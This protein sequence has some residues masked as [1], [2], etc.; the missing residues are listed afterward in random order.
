MGRIRQLVFGKSAAEFASFSA[1]EPQGRSIIVNGAGDNFDKGRYDISYQQD[2]G[3]YFTAGER[4]WLFV[5]V[6]LDAIRARIGYA[7]VILRAALTWTRN[8]YSMGAATI[9][10]YRVLN[11]GGVRVRY[12]LSSADANAATG[13]YRDKGALVTWD[14]DHYGPI[15]GTD[16]RATAAA[17]LTVAA[18]SVQY[19]EQT[20]TLTDEVAYAM[21]S[22]GELEVM[23]RAESELASSH[24][25]YWN[26]EGYRPYLTIDYLLPVE[27]YASDASGNADLSR[28]YDNNTGDDEDSIDLGMLDRP[29]VGSAVR[30]ILKNWRSSEIKHI[31]IWDDYPTWTLPVAA[32]GNSGTG[33]LAHVSPAEAAVSQKYT[34]RFFSAGDFEVK[35]ESY[36]DNPTSLHPAF[37]SDASW[38]GSTATQFTAPSGGLVIPTAAWSGTP[39]VGD[40]FELFVAGNSTL[41]TWL[42]DSNDMVEM[43]GDDGG[44]AD[45]SGWR[46][47][48]AQRTRLAATVT[49][50]ATSK[51]FTTRHIETTLWVIGAPAFIASADH[52][53]EGVVDSVTATSVTL[54]GLTASGNS[55]DV[56]AIV[57]TT[58]PLRSIAA[59]VWTQAA[60]AFGASVS[61]AN[62]IY[63]D[64]PTGFSDGDGIY[65]QPIGGAGVAATISHVSTVGSYFD[66]TAALSVDYA[67]GSLIARPGVGEAAFYLRGNIPTTPDEGRRQ[68]RLN[69]VS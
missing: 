44:S 19:D 37:D 10:A 41:A 49:I 7:P 48:V 36:R 4:G 3:A 5:K 38:Q 18:G 25:W 27:S 35:A 51:T 26:A 1:V 63:V 53:D 65:I 50:D 52:I 62:R 40:E 42:A 61:P 13:R 55:Y 8:A 59:S 9:A 32:T 56:G 11:P 15:P 69:T 2:C 31:E 29:E 28:L 43:T 45:A 60:A 54:S 20:F 66:L 16:H 12:A 14:G 24:A 21:R 23:F 67:A 33:V 46:G 68:F 30:I 64:D 57:G 22:G 47:I 39:V 34:I 6:N 17:S 58:L